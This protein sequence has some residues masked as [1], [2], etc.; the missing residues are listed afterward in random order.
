MKTVILTSRMD[1]HDY[2]ENGVR[3]AH[4]FGNENGIY[5]VL[6]NSLGGR[7]LLLYVAS[8][9]SSYEITDM[10]T[11]LVF[12]SFEM[13]MPFSEYKVLDGRSLDKVDEYLSR[14]D[15]IILGGGHV[16]TQKKFFDKISLSTKIQST[17]A[18]I[19]GISAGSMNSASTVYCPPEL[20][21]E[22]DDLEF[23]RYFDGLGLTNI[24]IFPHYNDMENAFLD[25]KRMM[26]DIVY[27]DTF[28]T[29]V[30]A[31]PDGTFIEIHGC[32]EP[33]IHGT[34]YLI[35]NARKSKIN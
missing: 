16:P 14:A 34:A 21:G 12:Q 8:D 22:S 19:V 2:D 1:T 9:E 3:V 28:K 26:E 20:E 13:T 7:G 29:P 33:V 24:N 18:V 11:N 31:I 30:Y 35:K 5:D 32:G 4:N 10:Y 15:L 23:V 27:P 25:N 6:K 17:N